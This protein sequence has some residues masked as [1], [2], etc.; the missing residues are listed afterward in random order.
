MSIFFYFYEL[1]LK[2]HLFRNVIPYLLSTLTVQT[3]LQYPFHNL[4]KPLNIFQK[5]YNTL[6]HFIAHQNTLKFHIL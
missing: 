3:S 5:H 1:K 2:L 6:N 4:E